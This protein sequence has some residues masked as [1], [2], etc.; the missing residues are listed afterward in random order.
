[1]GGHFFKESAK[2]QLFTT[3]ILMG[4]GIALY[5]RILNDTNDFSNTGLDKAE[6]NREFDL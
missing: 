6:L 3:L 2:P 1:L 4:N 5:F